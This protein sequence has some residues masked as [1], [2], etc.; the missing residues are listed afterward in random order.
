MSRTQQF[1]LVGH[2]LEMMASSTRMLTL[3]VWATAPHPV[4]WMSF[5]IQRKE[6]NSVFEICDGN[7]ITVAIGSRTSTA[8]RLR[9]LIRPQNVIEHISLQGPPSVGD[10]SE[11]LTLYETN[12]RNAIPLPRRRRSSNDHPG[13]FR[14][15]PIRSR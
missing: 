1:K 5:E 13:G 14:F 8:E 4:E 6:F 11:Q 12:A 15:E 7:G 9:S 2:A 10:D 3:Y